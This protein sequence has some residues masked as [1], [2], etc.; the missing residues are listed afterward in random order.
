[1]ISDVN[2]NEV[3]K[4]EDF[5]Y[6]NRVSRDSAGISC[7]Q[8]N[9]DKVVCTSCEK[10]FE[11][12]FPQKRC[13]EDCLK[14]QSFDIVSDVI[15][16]TSSADVFGASKTDS[17]CC[18]CHSNDANTSTN[19]LEISCDNT[20]KH[21]CTPSSPNKS[22]TS[23]QICRIC[24]DNVGE[25]QLI[26]PCKCSGST[27]YAHEHCL[28]KWFFKSSKKSCEVCLGQVNVT[29]IGYKPVQEVRYVIF[30]SKL[31]QI[32]IKT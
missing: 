8:T 16:V 2:T 6:N 24:L 12:S 19:T 27:K 23:E 5:K 1:M 22:T 20:N 30:N 28:L 18:N 7:D 11:K 17:C 4:A 10:L 32:F 25:S 31:S 29:P 9:I 3:A 15:N 26:A 21:V 14:D 13:C